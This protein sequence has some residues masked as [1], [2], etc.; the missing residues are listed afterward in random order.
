VVADILLSKQ[1]RYLRRATKRVCG[2]IK[3]LQID[4]E[5]LLFADITSGL[6]IVL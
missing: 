3:Y 2:Y 4:H 1:E 6:K 5:D